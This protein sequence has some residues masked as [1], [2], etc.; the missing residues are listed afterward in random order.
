MAAVRVREVLLH[1]CLEGGFSQ[2]RDGRLL[3][4][5]V[6][7]PLWRMKARLRIISQEPPP[8]MV[9]VRFPINHVMLTKAPYRNKANAS[10]A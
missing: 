5:A 6:V 8:R 10:E 1:Q 3:L 7:S 2:L 4:V 9:S